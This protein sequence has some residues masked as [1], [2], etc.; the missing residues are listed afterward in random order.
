MTGWTGTVLTGGAST[1]MGADKA[2]LVLDGRP[3]ALRVACALREAGASRVLCVGG[4]LAALGSL[5]LEVVADRWPGQGPLAGILSALDAMAVADGTDGTGSDALVVAP[6]DLLSPDPALFVAT[7]GSLR[8][9][10]ADV[11]VP[12]VEGVR[13]PLNGAYRRA[14]HIRLQERFDLGERSVKRA[15]LALNVLEV[16]DLGASGVADADWPGDLYR[17]RRRRR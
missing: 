17:E 6:C 4:D 15:L 7:V 10:E 14:A 8:A 3:M 16:H 11:A 1:R 5:G 9:G 12:V 13:Q 2:L